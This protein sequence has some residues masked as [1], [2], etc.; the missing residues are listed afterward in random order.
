[1]PSKPRIRSWQC[2][3]SL[4]E[5]SPIVLAFSLLLCPIPNPPEFRHRFRH[6]IFQDGFVDCV[7][8]LYDRIIIVCVPVGF[9]DHDACLFASSDLL[10]LIENNPFRQ[11]STGIWFYIHFPQTQ[12]S[13]AHRH[14]NLLFA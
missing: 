10:E 8:K 7:T 13:R 1:M 2:E 9:F 3:P 6:T 5:L 12:L 14:S 11:V 4:L